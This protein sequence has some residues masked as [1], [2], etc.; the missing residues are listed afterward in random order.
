M[1]IKVGN[2][3]NRNNV[4]FWKDEDYVWTSTGDSLF[5]RD[6]KGRLVIYENY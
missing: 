4:L 2:E 3:T 5:L 6:E 1:K